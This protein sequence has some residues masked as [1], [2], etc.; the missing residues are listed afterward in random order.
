V[1]SGVRRRVEDAIAL[2]RSR[3]VTS[4]RMLA[5]GVGFLVV[6]LPCGLYY[7]VV[8]PT[9]GDRL[10]A[11]GFVVGAIVLG[12]Y[13]LWEAK[14]PGPREGRPGTRRDDP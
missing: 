10:V 4:G 12:L 5:T 8:G 2:W 7:L 9:A 11:L 13:S 3:E 1:L 6:I 14:A